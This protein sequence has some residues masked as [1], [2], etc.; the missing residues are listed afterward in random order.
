MKSM[1]M[2]ILTAFA[3]VAELVVKM[4]LNSACFLVLYEPEVPEE[5]E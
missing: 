3:A 5:L 4:T 1:H 2:V